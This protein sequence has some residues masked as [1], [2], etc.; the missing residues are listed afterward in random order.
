MTDRQRLIYTET[1]VGY[2]GYTSLSV[3]RWRR[4][5][6]PSTE[7]QILTM[8]QV[9]YNTTCCHT[10]KKGTYPIPRTSKLETGPC[11]TF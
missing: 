3:E 2:Q 4:H 8:I 11:L 6:V 10:L 5:A 9:S 7:E 1:E